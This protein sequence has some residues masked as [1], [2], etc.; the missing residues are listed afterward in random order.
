MCLGNIWELDPSEEQRL[1]MSSR[2]KRLLLCLSMNLNISSEFL[3]ITNSSRIEFPLLLRLRTIP[4][5]PIMDPLVTSAAVL[6]FTIAL[7]L[8]LAVFS[9]VVFSHRLYN[10]TMFVFI[11]NLALADLFRCLVG[12]EILL[13][14]V[15]PGHRT[16][17][18][19]HTCQVHLFLF[20]FGTTAAFVATTF[21]MIDRYYAVCHPFSHLHFITRSGHLTRLIL[22]SW[23]CALVIGFTFLI[24]SLRLRPCFGHT[25]LVGLICDHL[26]LAAA[27]CNATLL[28]FI[29]EVVVVVVTWAT[30][31]FIGCFTYCRVIRECYKP[32]GA[33]L[34]RSRKAAYTFTSQILL[35][36][37][38]FVVGLTAFLLELTVAL[39]MSE[40][41]YTVVPI[42]QM[43]YTS[44]LPILNVT[45]YALRSSELRSE[46]HRLVV[47]RVERPRTVEVYNLDHATETHVQS[48][49]LPSVQ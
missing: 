15:I 26:V 16:M 39:N 6:L 46:V 17:M 23:T 40:A 24:I 2:G 44:G 22:A 12:S 10:K 25:T 34:M 42:V 30:Y 49:H 5:G 3:T 43:L 38:S 13:F 35:I 4:H 21:I 9:T 47:A 31:L 41:L 18:T 1:V 27:A 37:V 20:H 33:I 7:T 29:F 8:N 19:V 11:A 32:G 28:D 48:T 45:I 36:I 14:H